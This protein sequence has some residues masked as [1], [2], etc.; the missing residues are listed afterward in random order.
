MMTRGNGADLGTCEGDDLAEADLA[1]WILA[2]DLF[3]RVD[4]PGMGGC[5]P[6]AYQNAFG[7]LESISFGAWDDGRWKK[8]KEEALQTKKLVR[9]FYESES[10]D[11]DG[12]DDYSDSNSVYSGTH[13]SRYTVPARKACPSSAIEHLLRRIFRNAQ[14]IDICQNADAGIN[15]RF[16][17]KS[18]MKVIHNAPLDTALTGHARIYAT[19]NALGAERFK[20]LQVGPLRLSRD[21]QM[22]FVFSQDARQGARHIDRE[23]ESDSEPEFNPNDYMNDSKAQELRQYLAKGRPAKRIASSTRKDIE[24]CIVPEIVGYEYQLELARDLKAALEVYEKASQ[25]KNGS[26][27]YVGKFRIMVDGDIPACPCCGGRR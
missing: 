21:R 22:K 8:Y 2:S 4:N 25:A 13:R 27:G 9:K 10:E 18:S 24:L 7:C 17:F 23:V 5:L 15:L 3:R 12:F 16:G 19:T 20:T 26:V 11:S 6:Y 1:S 14:P